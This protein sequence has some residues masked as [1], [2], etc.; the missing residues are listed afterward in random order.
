MINNVETRKQQIT[1]LEKIILTLEE[2]IQ[3]YSSERLKDQDNISLLEKKLTRFAAYHLENK[4]RIEVPTENL[5]N[6]I[7]ILENELESS[8]E[9][10]INSKGQKRENLR[11]FER[12]HENNGTLLTQAGHE[13]IPTKIVMGNY[14]KKTY[15]PTNSEQIKVDN[16]DRKKALSKIET[17]N[18]KLPEPSINCYATPT[19][20]IDNF[21]EE[22]APIDLPD[23]IMKP[24]LQFLNLQKLRNDRKCKMFKLAGH[25]L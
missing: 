9:S 1:Q 6:L 21:V 13:S 23:D 25:K 19:R 3:K 14:V 16:I 20:A 18:W 17:Q 10:P 22:H 4:H 12:H 8:F 11:K 5:D 24:N 2:Q 7:K 15:M